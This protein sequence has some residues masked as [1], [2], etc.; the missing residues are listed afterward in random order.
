[1]KQAVV[2]ISRVRTYKRREHVI[3]DGEHVPAGG[4]VQGGLLY[5]AALIRWKPN[6]DIDDGLRGKFD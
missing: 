2:L 5:G 1:M 3:F 4:P 6:T